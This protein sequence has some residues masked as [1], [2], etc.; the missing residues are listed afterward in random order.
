MTEMSWRLG[1]GLRRITHCHTFFGG[2]DVGD[3]FGM[4]DLIIIFE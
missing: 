3:K 1:V 4:V 2:V